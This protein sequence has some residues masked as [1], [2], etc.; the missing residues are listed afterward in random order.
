[1]PPADVSDPARTV[2]WFTARYPAWFS[3][4]DVDD[5]QAAAA[6]REQRLSLPNG[7]F[8]YGLLRWLGPDAV[9][10]QLAGGHQPDI[11]FN[12]MGQIRG[13]GDAPFTLASWRPDALD[14]GA[15]RASDLPRPH[16]LAIEVLLQDGR[17]QISLFYDDAR[18][19]PDLMTEFAE[20]LTENIVELA[21]QVPASL[22]GGGAPA[23]DADDLAALAADR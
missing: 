9:R 20:R 2:G 6:V 17:L 10:A 16:A 1:V 14:R 21:R 8:D 15:E 4:L 19:D 7:G 22:P 12:Y 3:L 11:S 23:L 13:V 18:F 5:T